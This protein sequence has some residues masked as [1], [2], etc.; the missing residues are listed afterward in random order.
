MEGPVQPRSR[1]E[2]PQKNSKSKVQRLG[3]NHRTERSQGF[4]NQD[5][6]P[7]TKNP[8]FLPPRTSQNQTLMRPCELAEA[9]GRQ[10]RNG[11]GRG[12][13]ERGRRVRRG[14]ESGGAADQPTKQ[15]ERSNGVPAC[16]EKSSIWGQGEEAGWAPTNFVWNLTDKKFSDLG[17]DCGIALLL[18]G[19]ATTDKEGGANA[20]L[21]AYCCW[22]RRGVFFI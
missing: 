20:A 5:K 11:C 10:R 14:G 7:Q 6:K 8:T 19:T 12:E 15:S 9:A 13:P 18:L 21:Q 1:Q 17:A 16:Q 3:R 4:L 2:W 22:C